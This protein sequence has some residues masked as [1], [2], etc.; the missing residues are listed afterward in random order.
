M[1]VQ[2]LKDHLEWK[3]G[4]VIDVAEETAVYWIRVGLAEPVE[5]A[6][7]EEIEKNLEKKLKATKKKK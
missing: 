2:F 5:A 1:E 6:D 7:N 3:A 4:Q